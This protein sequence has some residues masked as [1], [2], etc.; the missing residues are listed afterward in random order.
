MRDHAGGPVLCGIRAVLV[1]G[2]TLSF[3]HGN[4]ADGNKSALQVKEVDPVVVIRG[5]GQADAVA[6][7]VVRHG[8]DVIQHFCSGAVFPQVRIEGKGTQLD[9]LPGINL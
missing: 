1:Y 6:G 8:L 5:G 3:G 9:K 2:H 7:I 4:H